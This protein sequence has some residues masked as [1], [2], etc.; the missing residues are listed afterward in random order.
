MI[1]VESYAMI[2]PH[3]FIRFESVRDVSTE[4]DLIEGAVEIAVGDCV[5]IDTRL[6]DYLYPL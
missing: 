6:W 3:E 4:I 1:I 5:L 2:H